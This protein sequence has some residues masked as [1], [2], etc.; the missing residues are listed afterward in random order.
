MSQAV[1]TPAKGLD[2]QAA[3]G[4]A[5][6]PTGQLLS[7]VR[8]FVAQPSFQ[9][10][11]PAIVAVTLAFVGLLLYL[12]L[13]QPVR[14][15]LYASL[16][17]SEKSRVVDAL[18][19]AGVDVV[20]DPTTGDVL[21]PADDYHSSRILL[22]AQGLPASVPEGYDSLS[23]MPMGTSRSVE[24]MRL[25]QSQEIE[26]ARSIGEIDIIVAARV[27]LAIPEK[28]VFVRNNPE[29]TA[30]VLVQMANGR[31]LGRQQVEAITHLVSSSVPGLPKGN[32]TIIDQNGSLL[33]GS[34]DD[35]DSILSDSQLEYRMRLE[36][37]YRTRIIS[38]V[39]PIAGPGNVSAQVNLDIDFTRRERTEEIVDPNGNAVRSSQTSLEETSEKAAIGIPGAVANTPPSEAEIAVGVQQNNP[40]AGGGPQGLSR[41]SSNETT[42]YEVS[43]VVSTV[44]N[45]SNRINRVYASV[46]VRNVDVVDPETGLVVSQ[47]MPPEKILEIEN[48]VR[49][50]IG[51]D[52]ERGDNLTVSS[53]AFTSDL[54]GF[55]PAWHEQKWFGE[56]IKQFA[57]IVILAIVTLGVIRPL[58][59]RILVPVGGQAPGQIAAADEGDVDIE[60]IVVGEGESLEDIKAKLK[61]KKSSI[62]AEMLD[63]A[64]TYDDKVALIRMMVSDEAGRVANVF[65]TMMRNDIG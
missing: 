35:P 38:L 9:R 11:F 32:V 39:T 29:P 12:F 15:T 5:L 54:E 33:S 53:S 43:K 60:S 21:V 64:N 7:T 46:L 1:S 55:A 22:A 17:E 41:R 61:P 30:S 51:I 65:K 28:S 62:S 2:T 27:H 6:T 44:Q 52:D 47:P 3:A 48:L 63:T 4:G 20:L 10:S 14:T 57:T 23:E 42:N 40:G 16:P 58:L 18:K 26:L 56:F 24:N 59:S 49:N 34:A 8:T 45:P 25:K 37:V 36:R 31:S 13:Q 19:N 50:V